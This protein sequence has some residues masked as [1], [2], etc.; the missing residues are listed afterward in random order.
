LRPS[1]HVAMRSLAELPN[2]SLPG[3]ER[4]VGKPEIGKS[5]LRILGMKRATVHHHPLMVESTEF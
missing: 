1:H 2:L 4:F 3:N 5:Q